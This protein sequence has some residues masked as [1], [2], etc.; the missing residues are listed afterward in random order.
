MRVEISK[1]RG[2]G[3]IKAPSS[4]SYAH[5]L[6][7]CAGLA[8]GESTL[9]GI[10]MNEDIAATIDCL[11]STGAEI[12]FENGTAFINGCGGNV[13]PSRELPCRESGSTLRF[14]I[15]I[16]LLGGG[17]VFVGAERLMA[18]GVG[19][20]SQIF[21][22]RGCNIAVETT[23]ITAKGTLSAGNYSIPGNV[24]SQ[25]ITGMLFALPLADG[26][27]TITVTGDFESRAYVDMTLD[28]LAQSGIEVE[29][30]SEKQF[31]IKGG[32]S[33]KTINADVEGDWSNA[34]FFC[35]LR[36]LGS[37]I[38][39]TGLREDSRQGDKICLEY[40][41]KLSSPGATLDMSDCPDLAPIMFA[42]AAACHGGV[43]TGTKRLAIKESDRAAVMAEELA[44][45]GASVKVAENSVEI[46]KNELK[47]PDQLLLGHN[48]H[49]IVM[50]LAVLTTL[51]GGII[52]GAEA[53]S[54]SYPN[55]FRDLESVG[56]K[57]KYD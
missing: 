9:R 27:S 55:F 21:E 18:R 13:K 32:Q 54:K 43:F 35:A 37:D 2:H 38:T 19:I 30:Q 56:I 12:R 10:D 16:S 45:L 24:S 29:R 5:R 7:I 57:V 15:P 28:V 46:G 11:T 31:F 41:E 22:T 47:A 14:L 6:L 44:K 33:Y 3:Q 17:G 39:V 51:T 48:D 40:F 4:K 8:D 36:T 23:S 1:G 52:D 20:Y 34:A 26:D 42:T 49:R 50:S 53:V 25:F